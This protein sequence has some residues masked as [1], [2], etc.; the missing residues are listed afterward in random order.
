MPFET[1]TPTGTT[2]PQRRRNWHVPRILELDAS[3]RTANT[4]GG[5]SDGTIDPAI[6][7]T[8]PIS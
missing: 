7:T 1:T 6:N 5:E 3:D 4:P 2:L 8:P